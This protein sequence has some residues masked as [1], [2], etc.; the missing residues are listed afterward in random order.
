[1]FGWPWRRRADLSR[2]RVVMYTRQ[3]CHLCE[4]A[5]TRLERA[6]KRYGFA[7]EQ[8]DIDGD[9]ALA[10]RYGEEVPVVSVDGKV[11]FRGEVNAVLLD[12]LLS[13]MA[14]GE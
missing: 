4:A 12:R 7:L 6:R 2:L 10:E 8:I 14:K 9:P 13:A 3:G 5:W 11:R 1:M